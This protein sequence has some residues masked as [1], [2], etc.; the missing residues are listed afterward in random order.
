VQVC[1]ALDL[2][3]TY[4]THA[5]FSSRDAASPPATP[6]SALVRVCVVCTLLL[7]VYR[8][9]VDGLGAERLYEQSSGAIV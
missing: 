5:M 6:G 1:I 4:P 9:Y 2:P 8:E 7:H 3:R